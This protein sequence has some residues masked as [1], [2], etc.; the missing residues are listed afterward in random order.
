MVREAVALVHDDHVLHALHPGETRGLRDRIRLPAVGRHHHGDLRGRDRTCGRP[1]HRA[2]L[3][4]DPEPVVV[5]GGERDLPV[6]VDQGAQ[7]ETTPVPGSPQGGAGA[8]DLYGDGARAEHG[9]PDGHREGLLPER[10][11]GGGPCSPW[12][13]VRSVQC[14]TCLPR[15]RP[16]LPRPR[17]RRRC[18]RREGGA[19][20]PVRRSCGAH[21]VTRGDAAHGESRGSAEASMRAGCHSS[22]LLPRVLDQ[23][24]E[25]RPR[26]GDAECGGDAACEENP[27][28]GRDLD[29]SNVNSA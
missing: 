19:R 4:L 5:V 10:G 17:R 22:T 3:A 8:F 26:G 12:Q 13:S 7:R 21:G 27:R 23:G 1:G 11:R 25:R 24:L 6:P 20:D 15:A 16:C 9:A 28:D 29:Y 18:T 2:H 14:S